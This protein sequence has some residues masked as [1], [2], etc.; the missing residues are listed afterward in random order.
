MKGKVLV[1][2]HR[3]SRARTLCGETLRVTVRGVTDATL[4]RRKIKV[5]VS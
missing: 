5:V 3:L 1:A 2:S 4:G